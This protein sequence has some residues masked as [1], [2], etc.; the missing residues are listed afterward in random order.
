MTT[1]NNTEGFKPGITSF[2]VY[3]RWQY[4]STFGINK[5]CPDGIAEITKGEPTP[6]RF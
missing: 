6:D 3:S 4:A 1:A 5:V 2:D